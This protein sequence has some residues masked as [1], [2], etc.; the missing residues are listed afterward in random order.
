MYPC[1]LYCKETIEASMYVIYLSRELHISL[2]KIKNKSANCV[3]TN[4]DFEVVKVPW[5][6]ST[7]GDTF[8]R[9]D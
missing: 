1:F 3:P 4:S 8:Y 5:N 6:M 2:N 9:G 7:F